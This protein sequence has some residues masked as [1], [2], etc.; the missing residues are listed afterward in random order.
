MIGIVDYGMG[1]LRSV[2]KA[3]QRLGADAVIL[4]TPDELD[5][6][7]KLVL[8]G[9]G[10]FADGM[11]NLREGG[12]IEPLTTFAS[13][14][15]PMLGVCLGMQLFFESSEEDALSPDEPVPG[16]ALLPGRVV[17]FADRTPS[18]ERL[19][20]PHMGWNALHWRRNDPLL[21]GLEQGSAV[22][23]VHSYYVQPTETDDQPLTSARC[24]YGTA[25]TA[26]VWRGNLWAVQFHPEKSQRVGLKILE[27]FVNHLSA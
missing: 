2:Q 22:Y 9:V 11:A 15:K 1:N 7:H 8:P 24:E 23:F 10:A 19:K 26:S 4:R 20:V 5:N 27:N 16:L 6:V 18:G 14:G 25:F 12:W 21:A 17:R 13:S 3:L